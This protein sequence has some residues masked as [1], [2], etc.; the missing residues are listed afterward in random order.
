MRLFLIRHA[1]ALDHENDAKR[2]VS[3]RGQI[4]TQKVAQ[5]FKANGLINPRQFWHS[6]LKRSFE[7]AADLVSMIG[8][9]S[10]LVETDGLA[11]F[12][13]PALIAERFRL[14]PTTHDIAMVGHQPHLSRLA[15]LLI[16]NTARTNVFHFKKNAVLALRQA[17]ETHPRSGLPRWKVAW[18]FSPEFLPEFN[19]LTNQE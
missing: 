2:P 12:D 7:T 9:E 19:E 6:P 18:H 14:Y 3:E 17:V 4:L 1:H 5:F 8:L 11:P 16:N 10:D 13:D 15:S